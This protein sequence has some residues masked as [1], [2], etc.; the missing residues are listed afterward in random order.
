MQEMQVW[1]LGWKDPL[2]KE[3]ATH[4]SI[5]AW[6]IPRSEKP[7]GLQS[8]G[9]Q[10]VRL[11]LVTKTTTGKTTELGVKL[12]ARSRMSRLKGT[13][14]MAQSQ[15]ERPAVGPHLYFR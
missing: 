15:G 6:R 14:A 8:M 12:G 7:G 11:D 2:E 10:R 3:T 5:L 4:F 1:F 13:T 9:S